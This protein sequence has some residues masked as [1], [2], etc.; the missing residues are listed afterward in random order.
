MRRSLSSVAIV[1]AFVA[2][3]AFAEQPDPLSPLRFLIGAWDSVGHGK[4]GEAT[5]VATFAPALHGNAITRTS[6]ADYPATDKRPASHHEDL[7]VIYAN[8][9]AIRA[10]YFDTEGHVIRYAVRADE[11]NRATFT[12]DAVTGEPRYRLTYV[13]AEGQLNGSFEIAPPSAPTSFTTYLTW[14][15]AAQSSDSTGD[16]L[17]ARAE[18]HKNDFDYLLGDW[19]ITL[20]GQHGLQHGTWSA[21]RLAGGQVVDEYRLIN[22]KGE[23]DFMTTSVREYNAVLD[24]WELVSMDGHNGLQNFGTGHLENGEMHIEQK[25]GQGEHPYLLR[26]RYHDIKADHFLW[27]ADGSGDGGKTWDNHLQIEAMRTGPA[28]SLAPQLK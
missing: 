7:M 27:N 9:G 11:P 12:S 25:F 23:T 8:A 18:A 20:K 17:A 13:R 21:V 4:P 2:A 6:Y 24:R 1:F 26:I 15:S 28:R 5:G 10:D 16:K 22:D 19:K 3:P 14:T